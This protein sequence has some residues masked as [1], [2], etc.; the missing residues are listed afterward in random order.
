MSKKRAAEFSVSDLRAQVR[1]EVNVQR[2]FDQFVSINF[3][4]LRGDTR[5]LES[6]LVAKYGLQVTYECVRFLKSSSPLPYSARK[7]L[8]EKFKQTVVDDFDAFHS[9]SNVFSEVHSKIE[10]L[11]PPTSMCLTCEN[12]TLS[13]NNQCDVVVYGLSGSC[14]ATKFSTRCQS[15]RKIYNYSR[16]GNVA[17]GWKLYKEE[18]DLVEASDVCFVERRMFEMQ[19]SLA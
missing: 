8:F 3:E 13:V 5:T 15:C 1:H 14:T 19:C 2:L 12:S 16:Y 10:V 6:W 4:N 17:E 9:V 18:R 7:R 11:S